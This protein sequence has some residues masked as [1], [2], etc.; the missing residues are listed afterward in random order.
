MSNKALREAFVAGARWS[1]R[2]GFFAGPHERDAEA[3]RRYPPKTVTTPRVV[4]TPATDLQYRVRN[5]A[6]Q[7]ERDGIWLPSATYTTEPGF[8][9]VDVTAPPEDVAVILDLLQNPTE[10]TEVD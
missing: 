5:G 1:D 2:G 4:T 8:L 7:V 9:Q 10:T 6:L 3:K